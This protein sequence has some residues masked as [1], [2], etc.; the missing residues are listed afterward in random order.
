MAID[1]DTLKAL[2]ERELSCVTDVRVMSR[3]RSLLVE[4]RPELRD[5]DYGDPGQ[6]YV[7]WMVLEHPASQT[8][9][10]YCKNGF[11]PESPWGLIGLGSA[12]AEYN[13]MGMDSG[14]FPTLRGAFIESSAAASLP[15]WRVFK[16]DASGVR[17]PITPE[18]DWDE[19]WRL[20]EE[21][22][23]DDPTSRYDHDQD[24]VVDYWKRSPE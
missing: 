17:V 16:T 15:I 14:W 18:G 23:S 8:G 10:A 22:R 19:T 4:P 1:A 20:V 21:K 2:V 9:I 6:Q 24:V 5:W 3:V 7:C 13:S 11:G 12:G